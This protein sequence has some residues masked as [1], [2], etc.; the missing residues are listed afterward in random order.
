MNDDCFNDLIAP[1]HEIKAS[2]RAFKTKE[3]DLRPN[4][5]IQSRIHLLVQEMPYLIHE[6]CLCITVA[7]LLLVGGAAVLTVQIGTKIVEGFEL[8]F[9]ER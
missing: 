4:R 5:A 6:T 9:G 2:V 7:V 1:T 3:C 8:M